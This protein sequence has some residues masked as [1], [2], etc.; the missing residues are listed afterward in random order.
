VCPVSIEGKFPLRVVG[1]GSSHESDVNPACESNMGLG[2][3]IPPWL[4]LSAFLLFGAALIVIPHYWN[5]SWDYG[6]TSEIGV[7]FL[8][9][10][11]LGFTIDR[12]LK[13]ELR[14]NAFLAAI[15]H[16]LAP[17][18]RAEVSR[19]IGYK[20][21]CERHTLLVAIELLSASVVKVTS[22]SERTIRN[23]SA[24]TQPIKNFVHVDEWG[25]AAEGRSEI[26]DCLLEIEGETFRP[27]RDLIADAYSIQI[28][29]EEKQ[30]KPHQTA[31]LRARW[32]E[33]KNINDVNFYHY[34]IPTI[35]PEIEVRPAQ[36]IDCSIGFGTPAEY[37]ESHYSIKK[38][39]VGTYFPHQNMS[40]RWWPKPKQKS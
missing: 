9:T 15:G 4:V 21:V 26:I 29:T 19:I 10:S 16:I 31:I 28:S 40:I 38:Q 5:W 35:D 23:K 13:L 24:Y 27:D 3:R 20:L 36:E 18:F 39:L 2:G 37:V 7:A 32:I 33:Y 1:G 30:L 6:I 25:H 14:T 34:T 12:W 22:S 17:E 8:V 11:I